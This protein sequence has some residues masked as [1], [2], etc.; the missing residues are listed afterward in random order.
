MTPKPDAAHLAAVRSVLE[1]I[2]KDTS[3]V[4]AMLA[5]DDATFI[6]SLLLSVGLF[7]CGLFLSFRNPHN[8]RSVFGPNQYIGFGLISGGLL[9]WACCFAGWL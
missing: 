3:L 6:G 2:P 9:L 8:G 7:F 4:R 5:R 1:A